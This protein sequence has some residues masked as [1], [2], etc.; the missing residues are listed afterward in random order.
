MH[1]YDAFFI[2][3]LLVPI[4]L[5]FGLLLFYRSRGRLKISKTV[6]LIIWNS[7][8]VILL[9]SFFFL[10][11]E[12]YYRFFVDT[13]DS[14]GLN[15]ITQRWMQRHYKPNNFYA[16]D[17]IDYHLEIESGKRRVTFLGDSFTAGHGIKDVDDR[18]P[19][20]IRD[21][22]PNYEV[23]VLADNGMESINQLELLQKLMNEGYQFDIVVLIY[24]LNDISY[25]IPNTNEIYDRVYAFHDNMNYFEKNSYFLNTQL[26][27]YF[28]WQN[29]D[30]LNYYEFVKDAYFSER[31]HQQEQVLGQIKSLIESNGGKLLVVTFP[32]FHNNNED[33]KF[34]KVHDKL[35][36]FWSE[37]LVPNLDLDPEFSKYKKSELVVNKFDAHPNEY[38]NIIAATAIK[39][40][41]KNNLQTANSHSNDS[42]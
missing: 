41:L 9:L 32:F 38:A 35:E 10:F 8:I 34:E 18:F 21:A 40:F 33:Y 6:F 17:N 37:W 36:R 3:C 19:N 4:I 20:I 1:E 28:A 7:W 27:R 14:F 24:N 12:V 13:T 25:L 31:W 5:L 16:R 29:P 42:K 15:K 22:N 2:F 39:G 26:F 23:H 11:G 30:I